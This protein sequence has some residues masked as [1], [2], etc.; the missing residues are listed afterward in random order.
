[1]TIT[2]NDVYGLLSLLIIVIAW[3]SK[4]LMEWRIQAAIAAKRQAEVSSMSMQA[5]AM[6]GD[7]HADAVG[8][9]KRADVIGF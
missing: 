3:I 4:T 5:V 7:R 1:M 2:I 8:T 9:T 6:L